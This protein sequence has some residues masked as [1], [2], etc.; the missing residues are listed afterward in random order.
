MTVIANAQLISLEI[1]SFKKLTPSK[2]KLVNY[3]LFLTSIKFIVLNMR[4]LGNN[5]VLSQIWAWI[6]GFLIL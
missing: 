4:F 6:V 2:P 3:L 1:I 5:C